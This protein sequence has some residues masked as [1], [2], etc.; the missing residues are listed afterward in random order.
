MKRIIFLF[1]SIISVFSI[2]DNCNKL[3]TETYNNQETS[4]YLC[5]QNITITTT[6]IPTTT[7]EKPT[8]TSSTP[9]GDDI[10]AWLYE[11][12]QSQGWEPPS[13]I[14]TSTIKST[15]QSPTTTIKSTTQ[16]PTTTIKSTTQPPT[17]TIKSTT[18]PPTTTIK[19][20][21]QSPTTTIKSTT[22]PTPTTISPTQNPTKSYDIKNNSINIAKDLKSELK[23]EEIIK[24]DNMVIIILGITCGALMV[25]VGC[26]LIKYKCKL[27]KKEPISPGNVKL[28]IDEKHD[29]ENG[30]KPQK[31][32]TLEP[33]KGKDL[34]ILRKQSFDK[35]NKK[36]STNKDPINILKP[37]LPTPPN[38]PPPKINTQQRIPP[39]LSDAKHRFKKVA[40]R[41]NNKNRNSWKMPEKNISHNKHLPP[42]QHNVN[43]KKQMNIK[44]IPKNDNLNIPTMHADIT[45]DKKDKHMEF[46][47]KN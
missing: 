8:T 32:A 1:L 18:Q 23:Q 20:T 29:I 39:D 42:I 25:I 7:T 35:K 33:F 37:K 16:S 9:T 4:M 13:N 12:L 17:T 6:Q 44:E 30:I 36:N 34:D 45:I 38:I 27:N 21:T 15:T 11:L 22:Q 46:L 47:L 41:L 26:L 14:V 43:T 5:K 40:S 28:K 19:S 31:M 2:P 3:W 24:R 10:P